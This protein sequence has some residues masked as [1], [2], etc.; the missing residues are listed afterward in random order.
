MLEM[1]LDYL[2]LI[3]KF[4][5]LICLIV[6]IFSVIFILFLYYRNMKRVKIGSLKRILVMI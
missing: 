5:F 3:W 1:L 2:V 6:I 4:V